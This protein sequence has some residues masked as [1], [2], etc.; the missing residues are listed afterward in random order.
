[1][2]NF[3]RTINEE[4]NLEG[5]GLHTGKK[6]KLKFVPAV[7]NHGIK[8]QRIDLDGMPIV[9]AD[10]NNV[11]AVE[12]GTTIKQNDAT[13]S[14]VEHLLAAIVGLQIDNILIQIDG[15]EIPILD[16][17]SKYFIECL[18]K[19]G[20]K[21][22]D[23]AR[24][25][26][27]ISEKITYND[28]ENN[29]EISIYPHND[30]RITSMVDY[31]SE[32]LGSQH[33]TLN[34]ISNFKK[35]VSDARTFCFLHEIEDLFKKNLIK[36]G[37]LDNAIV[38]VD[39][40]IDEKKLKEISQL[41][42][43]KN[44]KVDKQ[45]ILNNIKLKYNNEPARHKLLDI[46]G[47]LALVGR[48]IK[49]HIIAARPGHKSNIE[50]AKILKNFVKKRNIN[51]PKYDPNQKPVFDINGVK[52]IMKH[53]YPFLLVDKITYLDESE[54]VGVKNVTVNEDFFNGHF[55][56]NPVMPGVLQIEALA[57]VGGILVMN[58]IEEPEKHIPYL[59][60]IENFRFRKMVSPGDTLVMR[61]RFIAP[62]KRGI[63]KMKA[64]AFVGNNLVSEGN[65]TATISKIN[66]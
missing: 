42:G 24:K 31:N 9:D 48:P 26:I 63:A 14:T 53:R 3:Q 54:V 29:V 4:G 52:N 22:Q 27:E 39:K 12:R 18:E 43:K 15:E 41:L 60:G 62:I 46:V 55:P 7:I 28:E 34:Q 1:M 5:I 59:A 38:I 16:G 23:A 56:G 6:S 10:V 20:L 40:V 37:D 64:E 49:G 50:F 2:I 66:E 33:Y 17:S 8:F 21:T 58:S 36:G 51:A 19:C 25:Y 35:D 13:I 44:I 32:I 61:L 65:M 45:G 57:Q 11:I 47:D 30:Y